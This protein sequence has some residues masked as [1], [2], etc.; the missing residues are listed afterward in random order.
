MHCAYLRA[1]VWLG[2]PE[3]FELAFALFEPPQAATMTGTA[4]RSSH[5]IRFAEALHVVNIDVKSINLLE[6]RSGQDG[7]GVLGTEDA[8]SQRMSV[9]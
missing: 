9:P 6:T 3:P 8:F 2:A 7:G 4:T 1:A 5:G